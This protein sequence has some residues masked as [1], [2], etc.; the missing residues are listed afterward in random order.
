MNLTTTVK[1]GNAASDDFENEFQFQLPLR[2]CRTCRAV[3]RCG[4]N[5]SDSG[6]N[7]EIKG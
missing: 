5:G 2:I 6:C 4:P 7:A 3:N 1:A